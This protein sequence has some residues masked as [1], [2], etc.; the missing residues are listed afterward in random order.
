MTG[1]NPGWGDFNRLL[2]SRLKYRRAPKALVMQLLK[3]SSSLS[4]VKLA[5]FAR[6]GEPRI[7]S[8]SSLAD[9]LQRFWAV[10]FAEDAAGEP[11]GKWTPRKTIWLSFGSALILWA[12]ILYALFR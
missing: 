10:D 7:G 9:E 3:K 8:R 1:L 5:R 6:H 4:A 11:E 2:R 12:V